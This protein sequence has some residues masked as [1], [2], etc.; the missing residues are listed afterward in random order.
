MRRLVV[1]RH[2]RR[3]RII[4]IPRGELYCVHKAPVPSCCW[5]PV[6][7]LS[8]QE[9]FLYDLSLRPK[10]THTN[11]LNHHPNEILKPSSSVLNH[12]HSVSF[13]YDGSD[14]A[15]KKHEMPSIHSRDSRWEEK[16]LHWRGAEHVNNSLISIFQTAL[17][18][19]I[20]TSS[21][22]SSNRKTKSVK[23]E[24]LYHPPPPQLP[25]PSCFWNCEG[26][27]EGLGVE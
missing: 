26:R 27:D 25:P 11:T 16:K 24:R 2:R 12:I 3:R 10:S 9:I 19:G 21:S 14:A 23:N 6:T 13:A 20:Q 5:M 15:S 8:S 22:S 18:G 17:E 4:L 1:S 7:C